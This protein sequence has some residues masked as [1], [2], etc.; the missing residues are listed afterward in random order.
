MLVK[1]LLVKIEENNS[2]F[3]KKLHDEV[4]TNKRDSSPKAFASIITLL[5]IMFN[6]PDSEIR[7]EEMITDG[8]CDGSVDCV[9][10]DNKEKNIFIFDI[11]RSDKS[12][13]GDNKIIRF[14]NDFKEYIL[15]E[16]SNISSLNLRAKKKIEEVRKKYHNQG[17]KISLV[18]SRYLSD[19]YISDRI[20]GKIGKICKDNHNLHY[21]I[22]NKEE[23]KK[24]IS[25]VGKNKDYKWTLKIDLKEFIKGR[26]GNTPNLI[27]KIK[28]NQ[29]IDLIE[30][31]GEK[32]I[33]NTNVRINQRDIFIKEK[34]KDTIKEQQDQFYIYHN[35]LTISSDEIVEKGSTREILNPQIINGCQSVSAIYALYK[36]KQIDK[37]D[38]ENCYILC[39]IFSS[40]EEEFINKVCQSTNTQRPIYPWD[41]RSNDIEQ[42][43]I[44]KI[45]KLYKYKY[46]RKKGNR[47]KGILITELGQWIYAC[48]DQE[49]ARAKGS[50]KRIF[51]ISSGIYKRV[52]N[53]DKMT[54]EKLESICKTG[55][56]IKNIIT[57]T[58]DKKEKSFYKHA[59]LHILTIL[60]RK[61]KKI[62][63]TNFN[64]AIELID[65][66]VKKM[67]EIY[68]EEYSYNSIFK[69]PKT[70]DIIKKL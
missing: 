55:L 56:F 22:I 7:Q 9:V 61:Y 59:N 47:Q 5:K 15:D 65:K 58:K 29:I 16:N 57:R 27:G 2:K 8:N 39:K 17:W 50:K 1:D 37:I 44:E 53:L 46:V 23:I 32:Y 45:L 21:L 26:E 36:D 28:L 24:Y 67:R 18:V 48:E 41:L 3:A 64:R 4:K 14:L 51:D 66:A 31:V 70:W 69:N 10:F 43:I 6:F 30:N 62:N 38:L 34:I 42:K 20:K 19:Q 40:S 54:F 12:G 25:N 13:F 60:Y 35:G 52:F 68:G 33:Y 49:P 63:E 11:S